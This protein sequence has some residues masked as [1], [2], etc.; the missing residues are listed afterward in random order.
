MARLTAT[1]GT[2]TARAA[3]VKEPN[4]TTC[5]KAVSSEGSHMSVT[6][7]IQWRPY[8]PLLVLKSGLWRG[9]HVFFWYWIT[10]LQA[11]PVRLPVTGY[12]D[13]W[14]WTSIDT[15]TKLVPCWHVG[16]RN[17]AAAMAFDRQSERRANQPVQL[18][19]D[20]HKPD[21][22]AVDAHFGDEI[23]Y[24]AIVTLYGGPAKD[25]ASYRPPRSV[26]TRSTVV[27]GDPD[28]D[29]VSTSYVERQN[30]TMRMSMRRFRCLTNAHSKKVENHM[31]A[32]SLHFMF[33][34]FARIHMSLR[35]TPAMAAGLSDHVWSLEE[36]PALAD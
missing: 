3:A 34:N 13:V 16:K 11:G 27:T 5:A 30:C 7:T 20:R 1:L 28:P 12:G 33:D 18:S 26:G 29:H 8:N 9:D 25:K 35:V 17:I 21:L 6:Y 31:Q 22:N 36:I 14:T 2:P 4:S 10:W 23:D 15:D 32:V 19:T 24:A